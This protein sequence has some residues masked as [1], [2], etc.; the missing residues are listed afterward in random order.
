MTNP[1]KAK[2]AIQWYKRS[3]Q[4]FTSLYP[5]VG[6]EETPKPQSKPKAATPQYDD[7]E[8]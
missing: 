1:D 5:S 2:E 3:Q 8:V 6:T 7:D 4:L